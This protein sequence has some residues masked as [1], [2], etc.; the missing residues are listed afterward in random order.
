MK[1]KRIIERVVDKKGFQPKYFYWFVKP[2][3]GTTFPYLKPNV[4]DTII[5]TIDVTASLYEEW[6]SLSMI[7]MYS[8]LCC[9]LSNITYS[10]ELII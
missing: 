6:Y 9:T 2:Q 7:D 10:G 1:T 4:I 5:V 8:Y 3:Y